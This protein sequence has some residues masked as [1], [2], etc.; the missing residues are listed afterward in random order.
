ME[1]L[2]LLTPLEQ[3]AMLAIA[4]YLKSQRAE[5]AEGRTHIEALLGELPAH[6]PRFSSPDEGLSPAR[7]AA[8]RFMRENPA[9]M[10]LLAQ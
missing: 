10:R 9:L 8:R 5:G 2:E 7:M 3:K 1:T 6:G 4:E